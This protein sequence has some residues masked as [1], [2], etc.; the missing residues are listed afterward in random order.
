MFVAMIAK[1]IYRQ[2]LEQL[3][4]LYNIHEATVITDTVFEKIAGIK[5]V[6]FIKDATLE[7]P[8]NA[9]RN[10]QAALDA[11]L[12]NKPLQYVLGEAWFGHINL[13]VNEHVLIPRPETEELVQWLLAAQPGA[14]KKQ[15]AIL[16]IGTGSGCIAI[17]L[18]QKLPAAAITAI[19]IS[20]AALELAQKN[21]LAYQLA[22]NFKQ[23]NFL[24]ELNWP[25]LPQYDIII[26]N[27][28]YIPYKEKDGMDA[29]VLLFE[30]HQALFV[31]ND[32]PLL[33]YE[34]IASFATT[35][36][37]VNGTIYVEIHENLA[38]Q[39]AKVFDAVFKTV[40]VKKDIF[41]KDRMISATHFR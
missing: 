15:L 25:Q 18:Q 5:K 38:E 7:L 32:T 23:L 22:I 11:L 34:K 37:S 26:S 40:V 21:A 13:L 29:N 1:I 3:Q 30:P 2:L 8:A 41:G 16:D 39:T 28:P 19:D 27:P 6:D 12:Q 24:D 9:E 10:L 31:A 36:L 17:Y 4:N 20:N 35:H 33:F 14:E